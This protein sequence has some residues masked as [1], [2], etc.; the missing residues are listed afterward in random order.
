MSEKKANHVTFK[1][2]ANVGGE[3]CAKVGGT[4]HENQNNSAESRRQR[5][6]TES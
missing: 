6:H 5:T 1:K 2:C 4:I 3:N